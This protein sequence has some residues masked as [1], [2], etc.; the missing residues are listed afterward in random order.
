MKGQSTMPRIWYL[1]VAQTAI[2]E[3]DFRCPYCGA[4]EHMLD[5]RAIGYTR[6]GELLSI[7]CCACGSDFQAL[8][9]EAEAEGAA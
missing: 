4:G 6:G 1:Q 8:R 3:R 5:R 9:F 2:P 7:L